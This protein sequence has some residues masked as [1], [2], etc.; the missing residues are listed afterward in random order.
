MERFNVKINIIAR[1]GVDLEYWLLSINK[2]RSTKLEFK[3]VIST[4]YIKIESQTEIDSYLTICC[5]FRTNEEKLGRKTE[6]NRRTSI[7]L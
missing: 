3:A 2:L 5:C 7:L 4:G 1:L 6:E